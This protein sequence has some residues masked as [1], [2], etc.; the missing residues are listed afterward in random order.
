[1]K[2]HIPPLIYSAGSSVD[3]GGREEGTQ[4]VAKLQLSVHMKS[5]AHFVKTCLQRV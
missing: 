2:V 5:R 4:H 3:F 1:M